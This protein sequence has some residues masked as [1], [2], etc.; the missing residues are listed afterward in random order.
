VKYVIRKRIWTNNNVAFWY[1]Q[2]IICYIKDYALNELKEFE[3][4]NI[5][6]MDIL[7]VVHPTQY[8]EKVNRLRKF[9]N[10]PII[11]FALTMRKLLVKLKVK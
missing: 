8:M 10:N 5:N 3:G 6:E 7:S 1:K 2:N 11:H 9:E 4:L